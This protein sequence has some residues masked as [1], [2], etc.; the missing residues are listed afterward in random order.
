MNRVLS[1]QNT[2][3]TSSMHAMQCLALKSVIP[4]CMSRSFF[5]GEGDRQLLYS[6]S[7]GL[8]VYCSRVSMSLHINTFCI[9]ICHI[10]VHYILG[11]SGTRYQVCFYKTRKLALCI[12]YLPFLPDAVEIDGHTFPPQ[13]PP[14]RVCLPSLCAQRC[15]TYSTDLHRLFCCIKPS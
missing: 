11:Q 12:R 6:V 9:L 3:L 4:S 5:L 1:T 8:A 10:N 13:R 7:P 15:F 2:K 14:S